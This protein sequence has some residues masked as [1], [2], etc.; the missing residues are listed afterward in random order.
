MWVVVLVLLLGAVLL[1]MARTAHNTATNDRLFSAIE[2]THS[3]LSQAYPKA[4]FTI[5]SAKPSPEARN[6]VVYIIPHNADSLAA[7]QMAD[8]SLAIA[9]RLFDAPGFDTLVVALN[10]VAVRAV[11]LR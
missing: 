8:S 3:A 11:P 5:R 4:E 10:G 7:E 6:I 2:K 9:Q 1:F